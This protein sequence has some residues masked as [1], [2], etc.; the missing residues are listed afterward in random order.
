MTRVNLTT[1]LPVDVRAALEA[2][3]RDNGVRM[4][5]VIEEGLALRMNGGGRLPKDLEKS[6][7]AFCEANGI[8]RGDVVELALSKFLR[9]RKNG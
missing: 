6:L 1:S 3:A 5:Q 2:Y 4:N 7:Q 8:A 9:E